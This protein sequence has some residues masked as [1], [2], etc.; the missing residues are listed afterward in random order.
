MRSSSPIHVQY[1]KNMGVRATLV[2]SLMVGGKLWG[3]ISCPHY[4]PRFIHFETRAV[5][6]LLA[7]AMATR[8]AALESYSQ[9]QAELS[10]RLLEQR[11]I[12]AISI[13]GDWRAALFDGSKALLE[14]VQASGAALLFENEVRT[15]GEVPATAAR[16]AIGRWLARRP[17]PGG[18]AA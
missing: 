8:I 18:L 11:M 13:E 17:T 3:L 12:R 6:E 15:V 14:P 7:E 10:V 9:A 5:C 1:L 4:V 2:V 16:R